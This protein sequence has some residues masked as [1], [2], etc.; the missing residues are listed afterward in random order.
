MHAGRLQ[1]SCG[2]AVA[3]QAQQCCKLFHMLPCDL[4]MASRFMIHHWISEGFS[5]CI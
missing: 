2:P 1:I 3:P 5:P 4:A